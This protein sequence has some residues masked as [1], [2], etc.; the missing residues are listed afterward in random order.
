MVLKID[1][2]TVKT[3]VTDY[4]KSNLIDEKLYS[5]ENAKTV[6]TKGGTVEITISLRK[7]EEDV[8]DE[9]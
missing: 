5:I 6:I 9:Q 7:K 4:V 1:A 2:R 3:A 8:K